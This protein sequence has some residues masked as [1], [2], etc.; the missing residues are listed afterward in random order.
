MEKKRFDPEQLNKLNNPAR[1]EE[2][3]PAFIME[4]ADIR[5]PRVIIDIGAGTGF[6]SIPF[7]YLFKESHVYAC[8]I[9]ETM[10]NWMKE[11]LRPRHNNVTI[12]QMEDNAVPLESH[13]ADLLFMINL[14]HELE[15]P[16]KMLHETHRLLKTGGKI[17][18][19]D[20][21]KENTE[22]GPSLEIRYHPEKVKEQM[23][24]TGFH[25]IKI[26]HELPN[27]YLIVAEKA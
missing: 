7:A 2:I 17:A 6:F 22:Q 19:S 11:N 24:A 23:K 5:D 1:L 12:F 26:Y 10:V 20:W 13:I 15:H 8:D 27:N 21:K 4:K 14:H 25:N 16:A 9:S 3:P 18:I